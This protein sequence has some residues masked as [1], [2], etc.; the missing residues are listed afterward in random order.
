MNI[1]PTIEV[2][3]YSLV[4]PSS[5]KNIKYRPYL[6]KE[7]KILLIALES[8]DETQIENAINNIVLSCTQNITLDDLTVFDLEYIFVK[9]RAISVGETAELG[10]KC[11]AEGC[12]IVTNVKVNFNDIKVVGLED[13]NMRHDL[14]DGLIIDFK[15]P[16]IADKEI[17]K[18]IDDDDIIITSVAN[19]I[20]TIY[21]G[22]EI[23]NTKTIELSEVIEFL[24]NLNTTQFNPLLA[25]V[26]TMPHIN[27]DI[28]WV[29][30]C[31]EENQISYNSLSDF[32]I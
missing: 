15:Y 12:D 14:G 9:I 6:V 17:F 11:G 22:D 25:G 21:Y 30:K 18:D 1:L 24:G 26:L 20:D 3:E 31:G 16:S 29:C 2:P 27:Y 13:N 23:Y 8:K 10:Y 4:V 32:F 5:N 7:E 19:S 28:K